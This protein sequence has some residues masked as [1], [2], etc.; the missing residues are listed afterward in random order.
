MGRL[1]KDWK[2]NGG[3]YMRRGKE[4]R[5]QRTTKKK[6]RC[7][8]RF[9]ASI[10]L[11]LDLKAAQN[12][13]LCTRWG[14][15]DSRRNH[16]FLVWGIRKKAP[17]EWETSPA[18]VAW[19]V[20]LSMLPLPSPQDH[21]NVAWQRRE[22]RQPHRHIKLQGRG[23]LVSAQN[24]WVLHSVGRIPIAFCLYICVV[25]HLMALEADT[26]TGSAW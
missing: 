18:L 7:V 16:L 26:V 8:F 11:H 22:P 20:V 19:L 3:R 14:Q 12:L 13:K 1:P 23:T 15:K 10:F 25:I 6:K 24:N 2:V 5:T 9:Y 17:T 4:S 21:D